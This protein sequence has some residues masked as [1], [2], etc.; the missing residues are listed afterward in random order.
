MKLAVHLPS[1]LEA[2][3]EGRRV[4]EIEAETLAGALEELF[5]RHPLLRRHLT[6][7]AGDLREHVNLFLGDTNVRWIEDWNEPLR[8]GEDLTVLQ[9][10]SGG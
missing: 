7:E 10:V 5:R 3:A 9:A 4:V 1:L 2:S 6:D 8:G